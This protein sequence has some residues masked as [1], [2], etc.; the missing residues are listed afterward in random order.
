MACV[1]SVEPL[2]EPTRIILSFFNTA[3]ALLATLGNVSVCYVFLS[4]RSLRTR[5]NCY[6]ISM[7]I[8]DLLVGTVLEPLFIAQF[9]SKDLAQN[10]NLNATRRFTTAVLTGA[11]MGTIALISYD[12]FV[13]LSK[14]VHYNNYMGKT[15]VAVLIGI[16][17]V[18]P[19]VSTFLRY[20]GD[21]EIVY[22]A[23]IFVYALIMVAVTV[24][25]YISIFKIVRKTRNQIRKEVSSDVTEQRQT[26]RLQ[27]K[28]NTDGKVLKMVSIVVA[29]F[30]IFIFPISIFHFIAASSKLLAK[31]DVASNQDQP[32]NQMVLLYSIAMTISMANSI[33]N[34]CIYYF[35]LPE[36]RRAA[37]RTLDSR[38]VDSRH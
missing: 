16:T 34:P 20:I 19:I 30:F 22:S 9:A 18:L 17:W 37:R 5:S 32:D 33:V 8:T 25:S 13:H 29:C 4:N 15:K 26:G 14:T 10:C 35:R 24:V 38:L 12:R 11:T 36:F 28:S 2:T 21:K 27:R 6:L 3:I 1:N 23:S 7:A 31:K